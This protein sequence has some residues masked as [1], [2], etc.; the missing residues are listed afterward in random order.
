[1]WQ[2]M[3]RCVLAVL[4]GGLTTVEAVYAGL[5]SVNVFENQA[6]I[7]ATAQELF[8]LGVCRN[9]GLLSEKTLATLVQGVRLLLHEPEQLRR[10]RARTRG[11][12]DLRGAERVIAVIEGEH[13][14]RCA[15]RPPRRSRRTEA[16]HAGR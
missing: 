16:T 4:A 12:V 7:D 14:R 9:G 3:D 8:E 11:L 1:M 2:V 15:P 13:A 10:M 6:A 5:P